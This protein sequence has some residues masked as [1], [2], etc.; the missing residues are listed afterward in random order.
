MEFDA[1]L[2]AIHR[3]SIEDKAFAAYR[4]PDDN[5]LYFLKDPVETSAHFIEQP[6]EGFVFAPF[7]TEQKTYFWQGTFDRIPL[8][9]LNWRLTRNRKDNIQHF[10]Q[11]NDL[12]MKNYL[13][14]I[15]E[16][17]NCI[18]S[19]LCNK[20]VLSRQ[21]FVP[22]N[23]SRPEEIFKNL[24]AAYPNAFV[25]GVNH[26]ETGL[27]FAATPENLLSVRGEKLRTVSLAGTKQF[28]KDQVVSWRDKEKKEQQIVTDFITDVLQNNTSDLQ[29]EGPS[30][31]RAGRL[32]HLYTEITAQ[33]KR[34][35]LSSILEQ[36]HPTPATCGFPK[37]KAQEYLLQNEGYTRDFYTGYAGPVYANGDIDLYVTLRC[38]QIID[39]QARIFVGG[40]I[41]SGSIPEEEWKETMAKAETM[42]RILFKLEGY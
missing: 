15:E 38:M 28:H 31:L 7:E 25:M 40:G 12:A 41:T 24:L 20:I 13:Q 4:L 39:N 10:H 18:A 30:T 1:F 3:L 42:K 17:K 8:P 21:E 11:P 33:F 5:Y 37:D 35:K 2:A 6:S 16:A 36:L 27:W 14:K 32:L 22:L 23:K 29:T 19:G 9:H 26:P 34:E